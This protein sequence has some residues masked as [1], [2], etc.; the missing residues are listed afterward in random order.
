MA[1]KGLPKAIIKKYGITKKA[2]SVYRG[3]KKSPSQSR[4]LT[5]TSKKTTRRRKKVAKKRNR[6]A[7]KFTIPLAPVIGLL[8]GLG[9]AIGPA[10]AGDIDGAVNVLKFNY[11]GMTYDNQFDANGLKKGLLPLIV[12]GLVHKFVGGAPLN[13][14][15]MLA[16]ANVPI[17]R[18]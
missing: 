12:G 5:K 13:I 10:M 3:R 1:R 17:V 8:A 16:A 4:K 14:N 6:G 9:P 7:R 2:W 11:L 15:R 18:I